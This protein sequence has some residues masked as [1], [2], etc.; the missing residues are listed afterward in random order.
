MPAGCL[1]FAYTEIQRVIFNKSIQ[2]FKNGKMLCKEI[3]CDTK[4]TIK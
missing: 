2:W 1:F 4:N 3:I